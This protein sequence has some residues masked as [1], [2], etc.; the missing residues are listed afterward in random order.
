MCE[1]LRMIKPI[2]GGNLSLRLRFHVT[3]G[4]RL[5]K[6]WTNRL[7]LA[8]VEFALLDYLTRPN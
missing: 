4:G 3:A 6:C 5:L 1:K 8:F 7:E 2:C